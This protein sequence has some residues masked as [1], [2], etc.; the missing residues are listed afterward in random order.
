M[1]EKRIIQ[2]SEKLHDKIM[3]E[4]AVTNKSLYRNNSACLEAIAS[5]IIEEWENVHGGTWE[6]R[7]SENMLGESHLFFRQYIPAPAEQ[8]LAAD[9][10]SA[11]KNHQ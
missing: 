3:A 7:I 8:S 2:E 11:G 4:F 5:S 10:T 9:L 6:Y 1:T